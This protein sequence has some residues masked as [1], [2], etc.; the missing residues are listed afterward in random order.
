MLWNHVADPDGPGGPQPEGPELPGPVR[1]ASRPGSAAG[2]PAMV[3]VDRDGI[4]DMIARVSLHAFPDEV[5]QLVPGAT[6]AT[7]GKSHHA[8]RRQVVSCRG[9][10]DESC[11][12]TRNGR[13]GRPAPHRDHRSIHVFPSTSRP[14]GIVGVVNGTRWIG[15][16]ATTGRP[17]LAADRSDGGDTWTAPVRRPGRRRR[18][19][20]PRA[21]AGNDH[22][23]AGPGG[24]LHDRGPQALGNAAPRAVLAPAGRRTRAP[25]GP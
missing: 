20:G 3:D 1:P 12:L 10:R 17:C 16:D 15:L 14:A 18:T 8:Y 21:L 22:P 24:V 25:I 11:G 19:R 13:S 2:A 4:P 6:P 23:E 7:V 9:V 5:L